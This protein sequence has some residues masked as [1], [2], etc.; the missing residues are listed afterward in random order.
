MNGKQHRPGSVP[1][2]KVVAGGLAALV[3]A[4]RPAPRAAARTMLLRG[5][6]GGGLARIERGDEPELVNFSVFA[7]AMILPDGQGLVVGSIR[8]IEAGTGLRL[9]TIEVTVCR[10]MA[11]RPD[12][13]DIRGRMSVD[14]EGDYPFLLEAIDAGQPGSGLDAVR[15]EVNSPRAREESTTEATDADFVYEVAAALVAGDCQ[16]IIVDAALAE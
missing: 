13:A 16:W 14:G 12:G 10:P 5:M 9:Q 11:D 6:T 4:G 8:W 15:L 2:R 7:S 1:R 3:L